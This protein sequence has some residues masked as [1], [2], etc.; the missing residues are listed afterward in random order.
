MKR[1]KAGTGKLWSVT[2]DLI[3]I[4]DYSKYQLI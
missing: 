1:E 2:A 4:H 3:I